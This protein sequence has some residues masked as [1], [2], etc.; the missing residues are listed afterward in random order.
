MVKCDNYQSGTL[1]KLAPGVSRA[2]LVFQE[3]ISAQCK[4][5]VSG[6]VKH[7][8]KPWNLYA[9]GKYPSQLVVSP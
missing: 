1:G 2:M 9:D 4:I 5:S 7:I 6:S 8:I 3:I